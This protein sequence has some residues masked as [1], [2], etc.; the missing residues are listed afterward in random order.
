MR[1]WKLVH[2][3]GNRACSSGR[4]CVHT[5]VL[6]GFVFVDVA[7]VFLE[8]FGQAAG[9]PTTSFSCFCHSSPPG[10]PPPRF[11]YWETNHPLE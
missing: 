10:E 1:L 2:T 6:V 11:L 7:P 4:T 3:W 9:R 8:P 5:S